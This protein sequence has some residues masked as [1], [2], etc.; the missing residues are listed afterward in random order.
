MGYLIGSLATAF[1]T[2]AGLG[3]V[4]GG[5]IGALV[6]YGAPAGPAAVA[7]LLYRSI[8]LGVPVLLGAAAWTP[9]PFAWLRARHSVGVAINDPLS[10]DGA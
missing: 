6:L 5:L 7:V 4:E 8:S 3:A 1:P 2:P 9:G 10:Y